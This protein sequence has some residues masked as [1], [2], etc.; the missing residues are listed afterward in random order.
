[1]AS[2]TNDI[3]SNAM[4]QFMD[5]GVTG[6]QFE[7]W[8][9]RAITRKVRIDESRWLRN[10]HPVFYFGMLAAASIY[11]TMHREKG[12]QL[13]DPEDGRPFDELLLEDLTL[14]IKSIS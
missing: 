7:Y 14:I 2:E 10:Q 13:T 4:S 8:L 1:M 6:D 11:A 12:I 3:L 5:L 9:Q